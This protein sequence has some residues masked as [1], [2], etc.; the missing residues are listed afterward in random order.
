MPGKWTEIAPEITTLAE[1]AEK[2]LQWT[3]NFKDHIIH[4]YLRRKIVPGYFLTPVFY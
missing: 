1:N 2:V 3:I 4:Y